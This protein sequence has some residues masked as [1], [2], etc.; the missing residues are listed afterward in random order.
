MNPKPFSS[1]KNFTLPV[2]MTTSFSGLFILP[3]GQGK[4]LLLLLAS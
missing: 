2:G 4:K 3:S 1:S